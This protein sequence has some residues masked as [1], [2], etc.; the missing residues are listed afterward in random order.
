VSVFNAA[1]GRTSPQG[2]ASRRDEG[3]LERL[4]DRV[5]SSGC[6]Q[7]KDGGLVRRCGRQQL[8]EL[9][10]KSATAASPANTHVNSR[11]SLP[12]SHFP[13]N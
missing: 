10:G 4:M 13:F 2:C 1:I 6:C 12:G 5:E 9:H 7:A 8:R 3:F 11:S